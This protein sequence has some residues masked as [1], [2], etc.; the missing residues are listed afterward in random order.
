MLPITPL[1]SI[2]SA[3]R[4]TN[5]AILKVV[6]ELSDTQLRWQPH[7]TCHSIAFVLWHIARWTD[8]LQATIPGMT[9]A[10][11]GRLPAGQQIWERDRLATRW[12]FQAARLGESETGT[13]FDL[14]VSGEPGWPA[15][16]NLLD[17]AERAFAAAEAAL[18]QIDEGQF[19][20]AERVQYHDPYLQAA[21]AKTGTVGNAVMEHL[22]HNAQHL[23]EMDYLGGLIKSGAQAGTPH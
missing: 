20:A 17:Y 11:A 21:T 2:K 5:Q 18:G 12:G 4:E 13:R 23:G 16:A 22:V 6:H 10:L 9:E 3:Y 19:Q 7:P 14:A 1:R 8:H 15:K